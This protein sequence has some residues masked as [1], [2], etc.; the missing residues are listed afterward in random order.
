VTVLL[1]L[2]R[3][4]GRRARVFWDV[5]PE[6][7]FTRLLDDLSAGRVRQVVT[8]DFPDPVL[9]N[10][11]TYNADVNLPVPIRPRVHVEVG[12]EKTGGKKNKV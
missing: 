8:T 12:D 3:G 10:N 9:I 7:C 11:I 2:S 4:L 1:L 5:S 6:L